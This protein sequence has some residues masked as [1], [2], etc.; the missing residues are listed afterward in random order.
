[1]NT[2][3]LLPN[4]NEEII[5]TYD[6]DIIVTTREGRIIKASPRSGDAYGV[7]AEDLLGKSVYDLEAAGVFS[8]AI[9]PLVLKQKKKVVIRQ[10]TPSGKKALITGIPLFNDSGEVDFVVSYSYDMSQLMVMKEYLVNLESE[11]SK[12]KGELA[13]LRNQQLHVE[14]CVMESPSSSRALQTAI[15]M[16]QLEVPVVICGEPGTG[17]TSLAKFIH[18]QS[19]RQ[20]S[21][22]IEVNCSAIPESVFE[23]SFT[24]LSDEGYMNLAAG[25]TL[26]LNEIEQLS[27]ASQAALFKI[28]Q[29]PHTA[30]VIAISTT[31]IEQA[32]TAGKFRED[33]FYLLHLASIELF[34]LRERPDDL[35]QTISRVVEELNQKYH[36]QKSISD[37]LYFHLLQ[38]PW[39]GNFR[40]LRN[41]VERSFIESESELITLDDLPITYQPDADERIGF[42]LH[43]QT[44]PHI[45]ESVEKKVILNAQK[46]YRTTTEMAN[47]LGISQPSVVRKLKKY[48]NTSIGGEI[49]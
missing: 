39:K 16:A 47:I 22:F 7:A 4:T 14:G 43:G 41:V 23:I 30:R 18:S 45:L 49:I 42:E 8:P 17:K 48:T 1:M 46:R 32:V 37:D 12:V 25:G 26:V 27:P 36:Q 20:K 11:M 10:N 40:E 35:D 44:L 34:P 15:K 19:S 6:E 33:L 21:A 9:T 28:L 31:S 29:Q 5:E 13:H 3:F 24:G 38:L 2:L